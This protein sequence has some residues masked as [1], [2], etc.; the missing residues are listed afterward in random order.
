MKMIRKTGM[1]LLLLA[2]MLLFVPG[3]VYADEEDAAGRYDAIECSKDGT[4]YECDGEYLVLDEDG[5]G[6]IQ[7]SGTVYSLT[8][9]IDGSEISITDEDGE[10]FTGTLEDGVI[11]LDYLDYQYVYVRNDSSVGGSIDAEAP[12]GEEEKTP[13]SDNVQK[14][15]QSQEAV[16]PAEAAPAQTQYAQEGP[17]VYIVRDRVDTG[18]GD[19]DTEGDPTW[20]MDYI[21]LNED[22]TGTFLFNKAVFVIR[23]KQ[24][25]DQFSFTEHLGRSFTG[26]IDSGRITGTYSRYRYTF[27]RAGSTL[28]AYTLSPSDWGHGLAPVVDQADVLSD[29]Q[30]QEYAAKAKELADQYD[31]GVYVVLVGSR[32]AY[33]WSSDISVLGE[34]LYAGYALGVGPTEKKEKHGNKHTDDWKDAIVMT[35]AVNERKYDIYVAGDYAK[36]AIPTYGREQIEEHAVDE[37][38]ENRWSG[39][40]EQFLGSVEKVL[41]VAAKGKQIS[42]RTDTTGRMIGIFAPLIL[43]LLFGY[44][45]AAVMRS[46]MQNTQK[47]QNAAA[48]VASDKVDFTRREDRYIRT[49]VSRVYSPKEKSSSGSGGSFSSSS[50]G[51]HSSGSF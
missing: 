9:E 11:R 18:S 36:W 12:A 45:I 31:V 4:Y 48:Y 39:S 8:W 50:G 47:A 34:E 35:I 30:E 43:A 7:F 38:R 22:G 24:D 51:S 15:T 21:A 19:G 44:G 6:E 10:D 27:E 16:Q 1:M 32:D 23:W 28:P 41:K 42:F 3:A 49:L 26:T 13:A 20:R 17:E 33:T 46:S 14:E 2:C 40:V 25:G 37:L 29:A 5:E